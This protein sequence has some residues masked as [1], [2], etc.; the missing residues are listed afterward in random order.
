MNN[1][2]V[3][4]LLKKYLPAETVGGRDH[5][6]STIIAGN[7]CPSTDQISVMH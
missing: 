5:H 2:Q 4:G 3:E 1:I 7:I 6:N